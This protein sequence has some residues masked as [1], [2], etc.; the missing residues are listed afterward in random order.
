MNANDSIR[1]KYATKYDESSNYWKNSIGK[2]Q[3]IKQLNI[4][5]KKRAQEATLL[6]WIQENPKERDQLLYLMPE[7]ELAYNLWKE[8][9]RTLAYFTEAFLNG[10]ELLQSALAILNFAFEGHAMDVITYLICVIYN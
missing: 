6:R 1:I 3:S 9:S 8:T 5:E 10:P 7:L 2:N 4:L